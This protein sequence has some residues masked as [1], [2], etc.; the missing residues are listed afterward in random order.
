MSNKMVNFIITNGSPIHH[1]TV[2]VKADD[3]TSCIYVTF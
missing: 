2:M 3:F 1:I